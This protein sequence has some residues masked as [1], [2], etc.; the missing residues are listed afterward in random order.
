MKTAKTRQE[1]KPYQVGTLWQQACRVSTDG[2]LG[3]DQ[4]HIQANP[5]R[6]NLFQ[7]GTNGKTFS[8]EKYVAETTDVLRCICKNIPW[9]GLLQTTQHNRTRKPRVRVLT[10]KCTEKHKSHKD[11]NP[12]RITTKAVRAEELKLHSLSCFDKIRMAYS[13]QETT[14]WK[15][16]TVHSAENLEF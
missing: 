9:F 16:N 11:L 8:Q 14:N 10:S 7:F 3:W 4:T 5:N 15:T 6:N 2:G 13:F 1:E 12:W